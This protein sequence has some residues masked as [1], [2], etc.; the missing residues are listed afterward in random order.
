MDA[1]V[2]TQMRAMLHCNGSGDSGA[3]RRFMEI[4]TIKF[5]EQSIDSRGSSRRQLPGGGGYLSPL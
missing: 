2:C 5:I 3:G 1:S 4:E